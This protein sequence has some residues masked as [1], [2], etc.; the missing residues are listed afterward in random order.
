MAM[1]LR[2]L[3]ESVGSRLLE[4]VAQHPEVLREAERHGLAGWILGRCSAEA[5]ETLD[6][7]LRSSAL[8]TVA[9]HLRLTRALHRLLTRFEE[10]G[11]TPVLLKG[12]AFASRYYP[13]AAQRPCS[14]LDV[15]VA[16][17]EVPEA[18]TVLLDLGYREV[19]DTGSDHE[20]VDSHHHAFSGPNGLV[21]LHYRAFHGLGSSTLEYATL[22]PRMVEGTWEGHRVRYLGTEDEF[23]YMSVHAANHLFARL[24]WLLDLELMRQHHPVLDWDRINALV[25]GNGL[26]NAMMLAWSL[27]EIVFGWGP[28]PESANTWK[29]GAWRGRQ[30][31]RALWARDQLVTGRL[32]QSRVPAFLLRAYLSDASL[33]IGVHLGRGALRFARRHLRTS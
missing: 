14:D 24:G 29:R 26:A 23:V 16:P 21:E 19:E 27:G 13:E 25:E 30:V 4:S 5:T 32:S 9:G 31:A 20:G 12:P 28:L 1:L 15:L 11:L 3:R 8:A 2:M 10:K 7:S 22:E 18:R 17:S 6:A 33:E